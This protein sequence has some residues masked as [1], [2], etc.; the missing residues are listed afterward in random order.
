MKNINTRIEWIDLAKGICIF[1]VVFHHV[2][3]VIH[4][5][6]PLRTQLTSF[7]MP[8]YFILSGLFFK[9]YE[10]FIGFLKR[11]TNKLLIPYLFFLLATSVIPYIIAYHESPLELIL[12]EMNGPVYNHAIWFLLCLFEINLLFYLIQWAAESIIPKHKITTVLTLSLLL[13]CCGLALSK[14]QVYNLL[15]TGTMLTALPFFTFGWWLRSHTHFLSQPFTWKKDVPLMMVCTLIVST[16]AYRIVFVLNV[17]PNDA[18]PYIYLCGIAGTMLV[19]IIAKAIKRLPFISFWGRYSII[20]LCTHQIAIEVMATLLK[21]YL[22]GIPLLIAV[23]V[24]VLLIS[25]LSIIFMKKYMPHV[26]AQ[27]DVITV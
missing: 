11:K 17:I 21:R 27:K 12:F 1:L 6:Y 26:T 4:L 19:L 16:C 20:I 15:Y 8:L 5:D 25:H 23:L 22:S 14:A 13:G 3:S 9:Q 18:F 7:R 24:S 2:S 10:G